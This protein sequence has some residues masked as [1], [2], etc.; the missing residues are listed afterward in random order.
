MFK[1][2]AISGAQEIEK[3]QINRLIILNIENKLH[4]FHECPGGLHHRKK[5]IKTILLFLT[6]QNKYETNVL[7]QRFRERQTM[8]NIFN[9]I[10]KLN[11]LNKLKRIIAK[12]YLDLLQKNQSR[13]YWTLRHNL[14]T[15]CLLG[16]FIKI[17]NVKVLGL[18]IGNCQLSA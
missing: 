2:F 7:R 8:N 4:K 14:M 1:L 3:C 17:A 6:H 16:N 13:M 18:L 5:C 11:K 10:P 12:D 9:L 15:T